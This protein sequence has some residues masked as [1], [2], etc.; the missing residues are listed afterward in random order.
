MLKNVVYDPKKC[1]GCG[2]CA[3]TCPTEAIIMKELEKTAST[4]RARIFPELGK[5]IND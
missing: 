4:V 3:N 5:I 2:L 1:L